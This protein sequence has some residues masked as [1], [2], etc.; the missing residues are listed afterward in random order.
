MDYKHHGRGAQHVP[1]GYKTGGFARAG[2]EHFA[3]VVVVVV[4][5]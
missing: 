3:V 5:T 4:V 1:E 2:S